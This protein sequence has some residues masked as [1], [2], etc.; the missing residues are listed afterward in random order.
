MS[1]TYYLAT[2]DWLNISLRLCIA[3][4]IGAIIGLE[5]QI[6]RKPAGLRTHMLVSLGSAIFTLIIIQTGG[7]QNSPDALSRVIQGI[8]AG[9]GFL[10]AGEIVRQSSQ[11][12][13]RFEIHGLTSAAAIWVSAALGIAAGCGLW[14][15]GLIATLLTFLI[16]NVFKRLE[17]HQ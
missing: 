16:L 8:A 7:V 12:L 17:K 2:N 14:Q 11:E 9:I 10:G 6:S 15:L 1:N 5:R 4:A 13:Q 3:L